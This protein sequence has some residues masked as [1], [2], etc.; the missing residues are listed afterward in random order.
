MPAAQPH[1]GGGPPPVFVDGQNFRRFTYGNSPSVQGEML[2]V[3]L[4]KLPVASCGNFYYRGTIKYV[5]FRYLIL[6]RKVSWTQQEYRFTFSEDYGNN[7]AIE[8]VIEHSLIGPG[9]VKSPLA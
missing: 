5:G 6:F 2:S 9:F 4:K 3:K 7:Q 8:V 1:A